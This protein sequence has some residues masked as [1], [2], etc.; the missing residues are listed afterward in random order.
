MNI[1]KIKDEAFLDAIKNLK[2]EYADDIKILEKI[3]RYEN[4]TRKTEMQTS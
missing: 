3:E 1:Q 4:A 2:E